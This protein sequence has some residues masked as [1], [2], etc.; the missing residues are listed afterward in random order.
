[1]GTDGQFPAQIAVPKNLDGIANAWSVGQ[2]RGAQGRGVHPR[3]VFEAVQRRKI[4]GQVT[5]RVTGIVKS[6]FGDAPNQRHL[7]AFKTDADGTAGAGCL[8]LAT[9]SAGL[10]MAAGFTLTEALAPVLGPGPR[11]EIV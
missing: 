10:A 4:H 1:M 9:A 6:A 2:T 3:T 8:A 5:G 7:T 11:F